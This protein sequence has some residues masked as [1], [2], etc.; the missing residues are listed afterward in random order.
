MKSNHEDTGRILT[1]AALGGLLLVAPF[2]ALAPAFAQ[3]DS[4]IQMP[5]HEISA[6]TQVKVKL[7]RDIQ[8]GKRPDRR[9]CPR[10]GR[11]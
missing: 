9:P 2:S 4:G 10:A 7:L 11:Q 3:S 5:K 8:L 6:G 1:S